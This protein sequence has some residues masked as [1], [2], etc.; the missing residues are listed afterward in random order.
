MGRAGFIYHI[1]IR[2][3]GMSSMNHFTVYSPVQVQQLRQKLKESKEREEQL[4]VRVAQVRR[5]ADERAL[6]AQVS[7]YGVMVNRSLPLRP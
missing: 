4:Q 7:S 3:S 1:F 2:K 5:V 6:I